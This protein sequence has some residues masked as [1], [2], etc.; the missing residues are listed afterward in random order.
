M[1]YAA[2]DAKSNV[3][4]PNIN[5]NITFKAIGRV[6]CINGI[7]NTNNITGTELT[8]GWIPDAL[9]PSGIYERFKPINNTWLSCDYYKG[10][11]SGFDGMPEAYIKANGI[12]IAS[13]YAASHYLKISGVYICKG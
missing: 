10:G 3:D 4:S 12:I 8:I 2:F 6:V 9:N 1:K 5:T 11:G 13:V 7:S